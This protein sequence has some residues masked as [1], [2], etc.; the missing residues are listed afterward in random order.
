MSSPADRP[1]SDCE[2]AVRQLWDYLDG[3]LPEA[4]RA[5]VD[6]HL[7]TCA[8]CTSHYEFERG[9]LEALSTLRRDDDQFAALRTR[10][11]R[12]VAS[13]AGEGR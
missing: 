7:A 1:M 3:R 12:A 4:S 10:V 6:A 8:N 5:W 13:R 2:H 9:F 11:L